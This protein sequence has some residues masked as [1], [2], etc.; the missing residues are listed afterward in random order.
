MKRCST[1]LIIRY[2]NQNYSEASPHTSQ[3][4]YHQKVYKKQMLERVWGKSNP[5][6]TV[7]GNVSRRSHYG[8]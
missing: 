2:A 1:F 7:G 4:G 6:T 5:P 8:K 3:N